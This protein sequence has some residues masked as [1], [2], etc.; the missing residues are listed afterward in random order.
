MKLDKHKT[1]VSFYLA[2]YLAY[3]ED[4]QPLKEVIAVFVD[5]K[6][7]SETNIGYGG[8]TKKDVENTFLGYVHLGQHTAVSNSFLAEKCKKITDK[9]QY[10]ELFNE[11]TQLGYNLNVI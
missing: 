3:E 4:E 6:Y 7:Y 10:Q 5:E 1:N 11:L 2:T 8:V 9:E